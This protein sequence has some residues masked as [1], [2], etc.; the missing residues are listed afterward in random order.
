LEAKNPQLY[1]HALAESLRVEDVEFHAFFDLH[2]AQDYQMS[3][4]MAPPEDWTSHDEKTFF[5]HFVGR[6]PL[7]YNVYFSPD[8]QQP[9]QRHPQ[10]TVFHRRY[11]V[12]AATVPLAVGTADLTFE[13]VGVHQ[14]WK[15]VS[16]VDHRDTSATNVRTYG[17]SRLAS[18]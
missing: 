2:D 16:W 4:G 12:W 7:G 3:T 11:R 9:D 18:L 14:E 10:L 1:A 13:R 15:M 8:P 17:R 6:V 5:P